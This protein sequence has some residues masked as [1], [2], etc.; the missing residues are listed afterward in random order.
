MHRL[1]YNKIELLLELKIIS[2]IKLKCDDT[3]FNM[4]IEGPGLENDLKMTFGMTL[5]IMLGFV[6]S[7]LGVCSYE[8][9]KLHSMEICLR[10]DQHLN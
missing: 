1:F 7:G 10:T 5:G 9:K 4:E 3:M 2:S 6:V 8:N